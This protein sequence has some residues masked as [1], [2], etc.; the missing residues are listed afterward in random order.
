MGSNTAWKIKIEGTI[1]SKSVS[2][3]KS[4]YRLFEYVLMVNHQNSPLEGGLSL[5]KFVDAFW[6]QQGADYAIRQGIQAIYLR[7]Y[8]GNQTITRRNSTGQN[9]IANILHIYS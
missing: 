9:I 7:S 8:E 5:G 3:G 6:A 1:A 4:S 2:L